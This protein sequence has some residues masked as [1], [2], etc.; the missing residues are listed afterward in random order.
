MNFILKCALL[1]TGIFLL[2]H[3]LGTV[4]DLFHLT[5]NARYSPR[6]AGI[7]SGQLITKFVITG[8]LGIISLAV[9]FHLL[10]KDE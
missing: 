5:H 10:E 1:V 2:V 6:F 8:M 9:F 7:T 3:A 4:N